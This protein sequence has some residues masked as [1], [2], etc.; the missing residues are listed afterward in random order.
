MNDW[1]GEKGAPVGS[2]P[3]TNVDDADSRKR[4]PMPMGGRCLD[5]C[6][7]RVGGVPDQVGLGI[8]IGGTTA[9][10]AAVC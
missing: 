2:N 9:C 3:V 10:V 6:S 5:S 1:K 4:A 7:C 8:V